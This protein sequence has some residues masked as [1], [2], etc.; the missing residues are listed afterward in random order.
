MHPARPPNTGTVLCSEKR[1]Y[2]FPLADLDTAWAAAKGPL[3]IE[4]GWGCTICSP[5]QLRVRI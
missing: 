2:A 1:E 5:N 3:G 4:E